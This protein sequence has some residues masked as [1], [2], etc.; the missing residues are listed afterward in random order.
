M[1]HE[2]PMRRAVRR[3]QQER[4]EQRGTALPIV[5]LVTSM[6]LVTSAAWFELSLL[7]ARSANGVVDHLQAFH[8]ADAALTLC[9]R[10]L[11]A[12]ATPMPADA[13][14]AGEPA[15]WKREAL[16][17]AQAITPVNTWPGSARAPQCM[18][19]SWKIG[20]RPTARAFLL[21]ARGFGANADTQSWLQLQLVFDGE[22]LER[23]WR[24]IVARP[25]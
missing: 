24:R 15:S 14:G 6:M 7:A 3:R 2:F 11:A 12:G 9:A 5:L 22:H 16:F 21:T 25:F 1:R 17:D 8:A 13:A 10:S 19:E 23:H 20:T 4:Q 18:I